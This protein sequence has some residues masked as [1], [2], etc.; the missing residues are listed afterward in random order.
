[1]KEAAHEN[2]CESGPAL[3]IS[4]SWPTLAFTFICLSLVAPG[5]QP[6]AHPH[7]PAPGRV[8]APPITPSIVERNFS[9]TTPRT[10]PPTSSTSAPPT[11]SAFTLFL[12][13]AD[14]GLHQLHEA[15]PSI[16]LKTFKCL[17][18]K[19]SS[20]RTVLPCGPPL[21]CHHH[22]QSH[23]GLTALSCL[24]EPRTL[25]LNHATTP[26]PSPATILKP[27]PIQLPSLSILKK[28]KKSA[29]CHC[30]KCCIASTTRKKKNLAKWFKSS[31]MACHQSA[32]HPRTC[33]V[34]HQLVCPAM[35]QAHHPAAIL[36]KNFS[37]SMGPCASATTSSSTLLPV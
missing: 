27:C 3:V 10:L 4:S 32:C 19:I 16:C 9:H 35:C 24:L 18:P 33:P 21:R 17:S 7:L 12:A 30:P 1:M 13:S 11:T 23:H 5:Q 34:A 28:K 2:Y 36:K 8:A 29:L 25:G 20:Q 26:G 22:H 31:F 14:P 15:R 6:P 37:K